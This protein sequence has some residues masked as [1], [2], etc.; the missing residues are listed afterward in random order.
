MDASSVPAHRY[1]IG[2]WKCN[3][4]QQQVR[5]WLDIFT[6][7][8]E[9]SAGL[10]VILAP[11]LLW[12]ATAAAHLEEAGITGLELAAQD[13]SPFPRGSY[14]GAVA[15]DQ[16]KGVAGYA[17]VGHAERRRYFH[18]TSGDVTN[19]FSEAVDA[20][21]TPIVCVDRS[22]AMSQLA[23]L[24]DIESERFIIA[25]GPDQPLSYRE[26]EPADRV[27]ETV[28]FIASIYPGQPIVY[29]GAITPDNALEYSAIPGLSGLF[30]GESSLDPERFARICRLLAGT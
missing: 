24:N 22:Q 21:I 18:E 9:P 6:R 3:Q 28:G 30:V 13:I 25:Y 4:N 19:K 8:W 26:P 16:L 27:A 15:A 7:T 5:E 29:G 20:S 14:T 2:N 11:S 1:L 17:I 12:L 10:S 23:S